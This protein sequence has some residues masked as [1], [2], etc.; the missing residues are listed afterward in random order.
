MLDAVLES[1][2]EAGQEQERTETI[3]IVAEVHHENEPSK[4]LL[5]KNGWTYL[6]MDPDAQH[7]RWVLRGFSLLA[8]MVASAPVARI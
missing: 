7:E 8:L 6:E 1:I 2:I 3:T 4:S 5:K